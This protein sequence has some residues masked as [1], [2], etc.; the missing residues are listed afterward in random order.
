MIEFRT[1]RQILESDRFEWGDSEPLTVQQMDKVREF[2]KLLLDLAAKLISITPDEI[3]G[4]INA[5]LGL[6]GTFW[7]LDYILLSQ[8]PDA[9]TPGRAIASLHCALGPHA[10][11]EIHL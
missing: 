9:G 5:A 3:E 6:T 8:F 7:G 11:S 1:G 10:L 4:E 2:Y